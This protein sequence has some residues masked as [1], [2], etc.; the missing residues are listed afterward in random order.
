VTAAAIRLY[1]LNVSHPSVAA[2]LMLERKQIDHRVLNIQPGFHPLVVRLAG[3]P[4]NTVPALKIDGRRVQGSLAISRAL[5]ELQPMPPLFPADTAARRAV[6][7]AEA[8]GE[9]VL[10]PVPRRM[11]RWGLTRNR[12]LRRRLLE[13]SGMPAPGLTA[14]LN[15]PLARAFAAAIG[16]DD[17][18]VRRD[19]GELPA[20]LDHVD[21]LIADGV[22][23][24]ADPNAADFQ[25]AATLR[26][27]LSFHDLAPMVA[28]R[29]AAELALRLVPDWPDE[30]PRFLPD[31]WL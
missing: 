10:Q 6:E 3:F 23:G 14:A 4:A 25:I 29:P 16:A 18:Q 17:D 2:H 11:Y 31:Q 15:G 22:I 9:G 13:V 7:E 1:G 26:V 24:T 30:V 5:D 20:Q 28:W 19:V 27:M 21:T 8:W 12:E